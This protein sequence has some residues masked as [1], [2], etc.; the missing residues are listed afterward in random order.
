MCPA[1]EGGG[2]CCV[3]EPVGCSHS[4]DLSNYIAVISYNNNFPDK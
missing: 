1:V 3:Q 4:V 2:D